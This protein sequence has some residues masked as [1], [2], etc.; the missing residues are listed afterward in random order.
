MELGALLQEY[1]LLTYM[2]SLLS[3]PT[4][5]KWGEGSKAQAVIHFR[6]FIN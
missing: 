4:P 3:E 1:S 6:K 5:I 2:Q